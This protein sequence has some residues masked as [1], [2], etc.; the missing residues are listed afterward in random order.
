MPRASGHWPPLH[1]DAG[2]PGSSL[3]ASAAELVRRDSSLVAADD[4]LGHL[5]AVEVCDDSGRVD[6]TLRRRPLAERTTLRVEDERR[7]ERRDDLQ[8]AV[9]VQVDEPRRSEPAGLAG[10]D[11]SDETRRRDGRSSLGGGA[12]RSREVHRAR[13]ATGGKRDRG[14]Q[15]GNWRGKGLHWRK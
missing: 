8:A 13:A 2:Q 9:A 3:Q 12:P 7:V 1:V 11:R 4:D 15:D 10:G 5:V 6:A 14:D